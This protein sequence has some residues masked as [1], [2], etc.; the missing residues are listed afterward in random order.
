MSERNEERLF[1]IAL[2]ET[3]GAATPPDLTGR[4]LAAAHGEALPAEPR[5]GHARRAPRLLGIAA[6]AL[7]GLGIGIAFVPARAPAPLPLL[8]VAVVEGALRHLGSRGE[9][10]VAAGETRELPL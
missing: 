10:A 1:E 7:L 9:Q 3:R 8:R 5:V 6:G 4:I 2:Q